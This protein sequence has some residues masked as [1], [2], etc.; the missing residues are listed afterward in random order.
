M[1]STRSVPKARQKTIYRLAVKAIP[2]RPI[3]MVEAAPNQ[4]MEE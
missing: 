1:T 3:V 2:R 4:T